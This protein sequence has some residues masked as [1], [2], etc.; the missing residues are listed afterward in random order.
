MKSFTHWG[1]LRYRPN[2]TLA[3]QEKMLADSR[4]KTSGIFASVLY[5]APVE[6]AD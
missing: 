1:E 2:G 4:K 5:F 6:T 3:Q